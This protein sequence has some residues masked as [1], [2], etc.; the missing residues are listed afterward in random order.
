VSQLKGTQKMQ[1]LQKDKRWIEIQAK[2]KG[3]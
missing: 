1:D 2:H 3:D